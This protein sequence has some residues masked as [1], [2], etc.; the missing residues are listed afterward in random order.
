MAGSKSRSKG[1]RGEQQLVLYLTKRGYRAERILQQ[2]QFAGQ[3]DVKAV[4]D[5]VVL[6]FESK[7]RRDS[8]KSIYRVYYSDRDSDGLLCFTMGSGSVCVALSTDFESLLNI[9]RSFR[10]LALF[11]PA[12]KD[13]KVYER[14]VKLNALRQAANYLVIRDNNKPSIFLRY[15]L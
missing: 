8:F 12:K 15:W 9:D 1:R 11:P 7:L 2:Y 10:N 3:P 5:G 6:T 4:K 14:I 13:V